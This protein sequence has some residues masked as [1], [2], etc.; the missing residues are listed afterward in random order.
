M[1]LQSLVVVLCLGVAACVSKGTVS[2][3]APVTQDLGA[4]KT[5]SISV[6]V[7]DGIENPDVYKSQLT[8]YLESSLKEQHLFTDVPATGGDLTIKVTLKTLEKPPSFAGVPGGSSEGTGSVE[9][10]DTKA[11][12]SIGAF[13]MT[14]NSKQSVR[15]SVNGVDTSTGT[16]PRKRVMIAAAD[17]IATFIASHRAAGAAK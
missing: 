7:A 5:A 8:T 13:D 1:R 16:D 17:Q 6:A 15:T 2:E 9:L 3:K 11:A 10:V 14:A 4:F 12:K